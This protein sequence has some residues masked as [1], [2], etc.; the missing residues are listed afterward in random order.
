MTKSLQI[1]A[2]PVGEAASFPIR[3]VP[4]LSSLV[5]APIETGADE[6]SIVFVAI[7]YYRIWIVCNESPLGHDPDSRGSRSRHI[8]IGSQ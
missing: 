8:G 1:C 2:R 6:K 4:V 3:Q 5:Q 7:R